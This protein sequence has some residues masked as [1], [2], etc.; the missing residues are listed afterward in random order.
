[1]GVNIII[2]CSYAK[3][4]KHVLQANITKCQKT[5]V[6]IRSNDHFRF[7]YCNW[8][9]SLSRVLLSSLLFKFFMAKHE[10]FY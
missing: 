8:N 6:V 4:I 9:N 5:N 7:G 2:I 10:Y 1:M 3:Y